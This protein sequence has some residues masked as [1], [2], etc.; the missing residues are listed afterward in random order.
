[1]KDGTS[2]VGGQKRGRARER[3]LPEECRREKN[4]AEEKR[5][6]KERSTKEAHTGRKSILCLEERPIPKVQLC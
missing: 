2:D 5:K 6:Y 3:A 4:R 1:M